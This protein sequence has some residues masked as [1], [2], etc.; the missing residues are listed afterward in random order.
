MELNKHLKRIMSKT[1]F[2]LLL[3]T[4]L[5][6]C[7]K[8]DD[9]PEAVS[10][11][12]IVTLDPQSPASLSFGQRVTIS[13]DYEVAEPDGVRIWVMPYSNGSISPKYSYTSSPLFTGEGSKNVTFTITSGDSEIVVDQLKIKIADSTGNITI[14][15]YFESVDYT[16]SP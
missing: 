15:E 6:S 3:L 16:F 10:K 12:T 9:E 5:I 2:L 13:Y 1:S 7:N 14:S 11:V 8:D 4:P